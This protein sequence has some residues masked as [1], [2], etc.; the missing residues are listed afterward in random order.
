MLAGVIAGNRYEEHWTLE[1]QTVDFFDLKGNIES[2]LEL[3]GQLDEITFK[4][5]NHSALHPG[6]KC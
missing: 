3:T 1:K 4:P 6:Q 2:I 5:A